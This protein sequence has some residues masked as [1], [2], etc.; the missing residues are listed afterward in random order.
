M[1]AEPYRAEAPLVQVEEV[2]ALRCEDCRHANTVTTRE[3]SGT[4]S[5][6]ACR[7]RAKESLK[8]NE[9]MGIMDKDNRWRRFDTEK[10]NSEGECTRW[11]GRAPARILSWGDRLWRWMGGS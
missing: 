1:P 10:F 8:P 6:L 2:P 11:E 7:I 3:Y 9:T 5:W 4:W